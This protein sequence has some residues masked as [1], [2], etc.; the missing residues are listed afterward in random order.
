MGD[1][2]PKIGVGVA[3]HDKKGNVVMGVRAGSHGAGTNPHPTP[4]QIPSP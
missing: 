2:R 4:I 3:I 1:Q